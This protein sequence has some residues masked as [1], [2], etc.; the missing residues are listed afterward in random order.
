[1]SIMG[2]VA[3]V[4]KCGK[5]QRSQRSV[6]SLTTP[7]YL[8]AVGGGIARIGPGNGSIATSDS[9]HISAK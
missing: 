5:A 2:M 7:P 3:K 6:V 8:K 4:S 9:L 1:M